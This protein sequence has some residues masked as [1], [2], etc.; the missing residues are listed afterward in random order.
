MKPHVTVTVVQDDGETSMTRSLTYYENGDEQC[1]IPVVIES[2]LETLE[3]T[4][5]REKEDNQ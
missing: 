5:P 2:L 3:I 1:N 4:L